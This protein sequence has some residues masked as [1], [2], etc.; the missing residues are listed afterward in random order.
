MSRIWEAIKQA[1]W[2][3]ARNDA[4]ADSTRREGER[5]RRS[6]FRH[7]HQAEILLYGLDGDRQPFHEEVATIDASD[8]GCLLVSETAMTPGQRLFLTNTRNHAEQECRVVHVS[9]RLRGK[10]RVGVQFSQAAHH[11]WAPAGTP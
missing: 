2:Q 11:F 10:I 7:V 9:G 1:R 3:R 4:A 5:E 6:A 8:H